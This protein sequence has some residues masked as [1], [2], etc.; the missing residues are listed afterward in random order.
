VRACL[1]VCV[2]LPV[3]P[4]PV[5]DSSEVVFGGFLSSFWCGRGLAIRGY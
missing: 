3:T 1:F 2:F 4:L 5:S